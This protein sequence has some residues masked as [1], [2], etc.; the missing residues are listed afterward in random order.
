MVAIISEMLSY[1]F[2]TRALIVGTLISLCASLLGVVLVLK[3]Y[4]MIGDGLSHVGFGTLAVATALGFAP[5]KVTIPVIIVVAFLLL[6]INESSKIKGDSAIALISASSMAIGIM[7]IS[8]TSGVNTDI[9]N[10]L[11]GSILAMSKTD[12]QLSIIL[13][14][15]VIL[16]FVFFYNKIFVVT[17]D[18]NFAQATGINTNLYNMLIAILT[19]VTIVLGMRLMGSLL[20]SSLIIFPTLTSL[21]IVK[22]FKYVILSSI[23]ISVVCFLI[24]MFLSYYYSLPTGSTIVIINLIVF[25]TMI[26]INKLKIYCSH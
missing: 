21:Q 11:F 6:K 13:S 8:I 18:E 16:L 3:K 14:I 2:L 4:S 20:I 25:L 17:F 5:L 24:G 12:V 26:V 19:A 23:L 10:Y 15:V 1:T 7:S 22:T 9:N